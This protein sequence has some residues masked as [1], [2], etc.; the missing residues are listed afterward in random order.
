MIYVYEKLKQRRMA[1]NEIQY[2]I[3]QK[4]LELIDRFSLIE[5][6][7]NRRHFAR[8]R[9]SACYIRLSSKKTHKVLENTL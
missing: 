1:N 3:L 5:F 6:F 2:L 8:R 4:Q 9:K 7:V